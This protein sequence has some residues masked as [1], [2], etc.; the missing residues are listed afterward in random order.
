MSNSW[1]IST[2][3]D[4]ETY[5]RSIDV[6]IEDKDYLITDVFP[7]HILRTCFMEE[8]APIHVVKMIGD[9]DFGVNTLPI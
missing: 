4:Y 9:I 5:L 2:P 6:L 8:V 7:P 3:M 1:G